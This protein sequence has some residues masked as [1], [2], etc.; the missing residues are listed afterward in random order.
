MT[1]LRTPFPYI[2]DKSNIADWILDQFPTDYR[3]YVEV[4]GGAASVLYRKD[5][6]PEEVYNDRNTGITA[7]FETLRDGL[8]ELSEKHPS[9]DSY[10]RKLGGWGVRWPQSD[11]RT[12]T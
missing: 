4:F 8:Y 1:S 10:R 6:S 7:F 12:A 9:L 11:R 3:R 5:P 2:G